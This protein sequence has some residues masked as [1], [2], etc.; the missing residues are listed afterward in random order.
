VAV[1]DPTRPKPIQTLSVRYNP[2]G[3]IKQT[4]ASRAGL[5]WIERQPQ[6]I[7][8]VYGAVRRLEMETAAGRPGILPGRRTSGTA[9]G[10]AY[11]LR[12][13]GQYGYAFEAT[14]LDNATLRIHLLHRTER[15]AMGRVGRGFHMP[16]DVGGYFQGTPE[17]IRDM[18][19]TG[20]LP[21]V[22]R[23]G[24]VA[25]T[26]GYKLEGP[27]KDIWRTR[28]FGQVAAYS[29][30]EEVGLAAPQSAADLITLEENIQRMINKGIADDSIW[31]GRAKGP[32][33]PGLAAAELYGRGG[34]LM[35]V[36]QMGQVS[37]R[38]GRSF[39]MTDVLGRRVPTPRLLDPMAAFPLITD[40]GTGELALHPE[41]SVEE[42]RRFLTLERSLR[43][44]GIRLTHESL[45]A[46]TVLHSAMSRYRRGEIVPFG[47]YATR[48]QMYQRLGI[49]K[50]AGRIG[51][52][53]SATRPSVTTPVVAAMKREAERRFGANWGQWAAEGRVALVLDPAF[54]MA[55]A[56][57]G[58][59]AIVTENFASQLAAD[60]TSQVDMESKLA[61]RFLQK[62]EAGERVIFPAGVGA[63]VITSLGSKHTIAGVRKIHGAEMAIGYREFL[64]A[65]HPEAVREAIIRELVDRV[66]PWQ[67]GY[68][69]GEPSKRVFHRYDQ[70]T[71][72]LINKQKSKF[73]GQLRD[74]LGGGTKLVSAPGQGGVYG[75]MPEL[76]IGPKA[77]LGMRELKRI[78]DQIKEYNAGVKGMWR[79]GL[80][81]KDIQTIQ[82]FFEEGVVSFED[83]AGRVTRDMRAIFLNAS[84]MRRLEQQMLVTK[85]V[86]AGDIDFYGSRYHSRGIKMRPKDIT[87]L[88]G[89]HTAEANALADE[90]IRYARGY[91]RIA[92]REFARTIMPFVEGAQ[93]AG[94]EGIIMGFPDIPGAVTLGELK[95]FREAPF[96]ARGI[97]VEQLT[98][99]IFDP[100]SPLRKEGVAVK[101]PK[102]WGAITISGMFDPETQKLLEGIQTRQLYL[103]G[104]EMYRGISEGSEEIYINKLLKAHE[105]LYLALSATNPSKAAVERSAREYYQRMGMMMQGKGGF[106]TYLQSARMAH[107]GYLGLVP[108]G[109][110]REASILGTQL[111]GPATIDISRATAEQMGVLKHFQR[112]DVAGKGYLYG[113][114][115]SYPSIGPTAETAFLF[116][117]VKDSELGER[118]LRMSNAVALAMFRD[119]DADK[120]GVTFFTQ[121]KAQR[122]QRAFYER[123]IKPHITAYESLIG[124][125][126]EESAEVKHA[127]ERV[128]SEGKGIHFANI[129]QVA[130][131]KA[132]AAAASRKA[133]LAEKFLTKQLTPAINWY[134]QQF[135]DIAAM[136]GV[137]ESVSPKNRQLVTAAKGVLEQQVAIVKQGQVPR[138][139]QEAFRAL[140]GVYATAEAEEVAARQL[141]GFLFDVSGAAGAHPEIV[142]PLTQEQLARRVARQGGVSAEFAKAMARPERR[143]EAARGLVQLAKIRH[144][145]LLQADVSGQLP[146]FRRLFTQAAE[147]EAAFH[148]NLTAIVGHM[149]RS[150]QGRMAHWTEA[151]KTVME[152][153][154]LGKAMGY[155]TGQ[156][157]AAMTA[158]KERIA[159][160][161]SETAA[162]N[163]AMKEAGKVGGTVLDRVTSWFSRA[164]VPYWQKAGVITGAALVTGAVA[165]NMFFP[166]YGP[167]EPPPSPPSEVYVP[168]PMVRPSPQIVDAGRDV[169]APQPHMMHRKP[170]GLWAYVAGQAGYDPEYYD[171]DPGQKMPQAV[172]NFGRAVAMPGIGLD[173]GPGIADSRSRPMILS[174]PPV[175]GGAPLPPAMPATEAHGPE[176]DMGVPEGPTARVALP[177]YM[178]FG[179]MVDAR[180]P[181]GDDALALMEAVRVGGFG[182][183]I[184]LDIMNDPMESPL[185]VWQAIGEQENSSF[186]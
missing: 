121:R 34:S 73:L 176:I 161:V 148:T 57:S 131:E 26:R 150:A 177:D 13:M 183:N 40:P 172:P 18:Q 1:D 153:I 17:H 138:G 60:V 42:V 23:A 83:E 98:E 3:E 33:P 92:K 143:L 59:G 2:A 130:E 139:A 81:K 77:Q 19:R 147:H 55:T 99:S 155:Q 170:G 180:Q 86:G 134:L 184:Q 101:L 69:T 44:R 54:E 12:E 171:V 48:H 72:D 63:N 128:K 166:G 88:R 38:A 137:L 94:T 182:N 49:T 95:R 144:R 6:A 112:A 93:V 51:A 154:G 152:F 61:T 85:A 120:A 39:R 21:E 174:G 15:G 30:A 76:Q 115:T 133:R 32:L 124:V 164:D 74:I 142:G 140:S 132:G 20:V 41:A 66:G 5:K 16:L 11:M 135:R 35:D 186:T 47:E 64:G 129:L 25:R 125:M 126:S 70:P 68:Y 31:V 185:D 167:D 175:G 24:Y 107:S 97:S 100:T 173:V 89:W 109:I 84:V 29:V 56:A 50:V 162:M 110:G 168:P 149:E 127:L 165:K 58:G 116:R 104:L 181:V 151:E 179:Q 87:S 91:R 118:Q 67:R 75:T 7:R 145:E 9:A 108:G 71:R 53:R 158:A 114:L 117:M 45:K 22:S 136:P 105:N 113:R 14:I 78:Q 82:D 159:K 96:G 80:G 27:S 122:L 146:G 141:S 160:G 169:M 156:D 79:G 65:K 123:T 28:S 46:E 37:M 4:A 43:E 106:L 52:V 36:F 178:R 119:F 111:A 10:V 102:K 62:T 90:Y 8:Q 163:Q 157:I 103:P